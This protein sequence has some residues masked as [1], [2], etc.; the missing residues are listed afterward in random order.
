M[1]CVETADGQD[2]NKSLAADAPLEARW[3][4]DLLGG[5]TVLRGAWSDGSPLTAIPFFTRN[6]R[7]LGARG[8]SPQE[9]APFTA[10]SAATPAPFTA[11]AAAAAQAAPKTEPAASLAHG[12]K[13]WIAE[14]P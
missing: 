7:W 4:K 3:E 14:K 5:V 10:E 6:N 9:A 1:Y 8:Q 13:V 2:I 11:E 12:S